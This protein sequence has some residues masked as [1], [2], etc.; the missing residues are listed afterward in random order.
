MS[1][2]ISPAATIAASLIN[3]QSA[4][5]CVELNK[6]RVMGGQKTRITRQNPGNSGPLYKLIGTHTFDLAFTTME[7]F[8]A[9]AKADLLKTVTAGQVHGHALRVWF[10]YFDLF[11]W[12]KTPLCLDTNMGRFYK[13]H[14]ALAGLVGEGVA[15]LFMQHKDYIYWDHAEL[16]L[17]RAAAA[18]A[19]QAHPQ[20]LP[21]PPAQISPTTP[22][23]MAG[24]P[25]AAVNATRHADFICEDHQGNYALAEAKGGFIDPAATFRPPIKTNLSDGV[26]QLNALRARFNITP[27]NSY[28]IGA[29]LRETLNPEPSLVAFT[30]PVATPRPTDDFPDDWIRRANYA[31]WLI[32]MGFIRTGIA[33]RLRADAKLRLVCLPVVTI[34]SFEFAVV[35]RNVFGSDPLELATH[36]NRPCDR[37]PAVD[38]SMIA[39]LGLRGELAA[40]HVYGIEVHTLAEVSNAAKNGADRSLL[41]LRAV[42]IAAQQRTEGW[43]DGS[44][45]PDGTLFGFLYPQKAKGISIHF[46]QFSL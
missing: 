26:T 4:L 42:E 39:A 9:I 22:G 20:S 35:I 8:H 32:G 1:I 13:S 33:M 38:L 34:S 12:T 10:R 14:S 36:P 16:L 46:R 11:D 29:Y 45:F 31:A 40:L 15:L 28:A 24:A 2:L 27:K 7:F 17:Q 18:G 44:I 6:Q 41:R 30:D 5:P 37:Q 3:L 25:T 23:A 21:H 43:F 19:L